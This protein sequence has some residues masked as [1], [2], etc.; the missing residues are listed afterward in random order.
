MPAAFE[1]AR[2]GLTNIASCVPLC[3][4]HLVPFTS[5]HR[6][7]FDYRPPANC[8]SYCIECSAERNSL[9]TP[10]VISFGV[11]YAQHGALRLEGCLEPQFPTSYAVCVANIASVRIAAS[12]NQ[13]TLLGDTSNG[14]QVSVLT[15]P[16]LQPIFTSSVSVRRLP[17]ADSA[18]DCACGPWFTDWI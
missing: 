18:G 12:S 1:N 9:R 11:I 7:M 4:T 14:V 2:L 3:R 13:F 17:S 8:H 10:F 16:A 5:R 15:T 6:T